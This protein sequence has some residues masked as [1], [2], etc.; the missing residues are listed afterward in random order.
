MTVNGETT[1]GTLADGTY[2]FTVTGPDK[3]SSTQTITVSKGVSN[4]VQID[5]LV[6]G[7]YTVT[8]DTSKNPAGMSLVGKNGIEV[9]VTANNTANVP[10]AEFTNN[11]DVGSLRIEKHVV[12]T[13]AKD[14]V[15]TFEIALTAPDGITLDPTYPASQNGTTAT[16]NVSNGKVTVTLKADEYYEINELPAGTSYT[17]TETATSI[18]KGYTLKESS[19]TNGTISKE[20]ATAVFTNT[21]NAT[22]NLPL[23]GK[24]TITSKPATMD[25]SEFKFTVKEG[26][27]V[28]ATGESDA[29][30]NITFT[31]INYT[32]ANVGTHTYV[33]S[34][35]ANSKPGVTNT[36]ET[37]TVIVSVTDNGDGT[38]KVDATTDSPATIN[39][40]DFTNVYAA[41]GKG[42]IL[43]QKVLD[44]RE[45]TDD[46][47]FTFT[48]TPNGDAP[49]PTISE[50]EIV[51]ADLDQTKSF[52]TITFTKAGTY[53]YTVKET[54]GDAKGITYD[55]AEHT[56][57]F[58]VVD[59]GMGHIVPA[60]EDETLIK[61]ETITNIYTDIKVKK[62]DDKGNPVKGAE[63]AVK[64]KNGVIVAKWTTDGSVHEVEGLVPDE[65]Y[66]L[67]ELK[68][69]EGYQK[70]AD[71]TF[72]TGP[73]GRVQVLTMVD[74]KTVIPDTSDHNSIPGW[75]AGML[76]SMLVAVAAFLMRKRYGIN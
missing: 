32:M 48:I 70:S 63:L 62:V 29:D 15:F 23:S 66:T 27:T 45:W 40:V 47:K 50:I 67:T 28:V 58:T 74:K 7:T 14:K 21:Y 4:E 65:T 2:T 3:Y 6:P 76:M 61:K 51:K 30:G 64:D 59:D 44:G 56:V 37:Q 9:T 24:K 69:P 22:G 42:E 52:G 60:T 19:G 36:T 46:D 71:I 49:K 54:K 57:T 1:T 31:Q 55:T 73:D 26:E 68:V 18:P 75:T 8:E 10:T 43:V 13:T 20:K 38:L 33:V 35:D 53:T 5:D 25:L 12:G 72:S 39:A 17:V 11:K 41:E 34:E 16:A